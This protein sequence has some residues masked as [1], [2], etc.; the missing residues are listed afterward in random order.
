MKW[1]RERTFGTTGR[2]VGGFASGLAWKSWHHGGMAALAEM[3]EE[4]R[5]ARIRAEV[6]LVLARSCCPS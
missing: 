2:A 3:F 1:E 5:R 4:D 6:D